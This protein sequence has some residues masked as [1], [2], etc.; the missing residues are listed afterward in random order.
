MLTLAHWQAHK[1]K[2]RT[3]NTAKAVYLLKSDYKWCLSGTPFQ[4]RIGELYSLVRF[5]RM[6]PFAF[7]YCRHK[8]KDGKPCRCERVEWKFEGDEQKSRYCSVCKH[9]PMMHYSHFNK[10]IINPI[11]RNG[12]QG[13]GRK[14]FLALKHE[15][16]DKLLLRRTKVGCAK[17]VNLPP[18]TIEICDPGQ[19]PEEKDFYEC[20]YMQ[21]QASFNA[22][23]D[24]GTVL[25]NYAHIF[26]LLS[27]L[28]QAADH[29]YLVVH[30]AAG[31]EYKGKTVAEHA[32]ALGKTDA[33]EEDGAAPLED[34]PVVDDGAAVSQGETGGSSS[35]V[36]AVCGICQDGV[37]AEECAVG[38]CKHAFHQSCIMD[39]VDANPNADSDEPVGCP[40][41][42]Q[43]LSVDFKPPDTP[44]VAEPGEGEELTDAEMRAHAPPQ[45]KKSI[46]NKLD[47]DN[48][49]TSSKVEKLTEMLKELGKGDKAIVFSQ[50][51]NMIDLV[52]WRLKKARIKTVKLLG[53]MP[54]NMRRCML[55][56]FKHD[57]SVSVIL[58]SLK[59][60][61]EGLNLQV[62]NN[63]F[64]LEPWW[65]PAVE[66]QA[67]QRAHRIGQTKP[68]RAVRFITKETIEEKMYQLQEK[69]Q[70][71]FDGT[72]DAKVEALS[73]L[74]DDDLQF[75][76]KN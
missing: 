11:T 26:D 15:V 33:E 39:Y 23:V 35:G 53:S 10:N 34:E 70:L 72:V 66:A 65:N 49:I 8:G 38:G 13:D 27:K 63:V 42:F 59:A 20:I 74:T 67:I 25:H 17:D 7:Y 6:K 31:R 50:Y 55:D 2:G 64:V 47:L 36:V 58:M 71:V 1:I 12:G 57:A 21:T 9:P 29:P 51:T 69:K 14:G 45:L 3:T 40:V 19:T 61:G 60:G 18:L 44:M 37:I 16:L 24:K 32:E 46:L 22:F 5:L 30:A 41:C 28:R 43:P 68:V 48:F 75:L 56:A 52:E 4:N 54:L 76:F 73:K 62:A